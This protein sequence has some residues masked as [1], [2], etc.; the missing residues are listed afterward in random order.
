LST[1]LA[2]LGA[3]AVLGAPR[4]L[5][6][7]RQVRR[8]G[9]LEVAGRGA[10]HVETLQTQ[11]VGTPFQQRDADGYRQRITNAGQVPVKQLLLQILG[12]GGDNH[13]PARQHSGDQIREGLSGAG[14]RLTDEHATLIEGT[15]DGCGHL[16]LL[17]P[18]VKTLDGIL[19][20]PVLGEGL[21]DCKH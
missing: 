9:G 10:V 12:A 15:G 8:H 20:R 3:I 18:G 19:Q 2:E 16:L 7:A 13:A 21:S 11:I 5:T 17:W 6:Y 14:A 1:Y 4:P